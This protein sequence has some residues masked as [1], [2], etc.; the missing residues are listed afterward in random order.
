MGGEDPPGVG[1]ARSPSEAG[2]ALLEDGTD[3]TPSAEG[4]CISQTVFPDKEEYGDANEFGSNL[5]SEFWRIQQRSFLLTCSGRGKPKLPNRI[6][7]APASVH[8]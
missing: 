3:G 7:E 4:A 2:S 6:P 1:S 5:A 8:F